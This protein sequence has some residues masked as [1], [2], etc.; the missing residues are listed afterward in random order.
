MAK[1]I[2][3]QPMTGSQR[4]AASRARRLAA[5]E[6]LLPVGFISKWDP[7][8]ETVLL[9]DQVKAVLELYEHLL[10]LTLRQIFYR[11]VG[12]HDYEKSEKA[13]NR[14]K[15]KLILARRA[16][17][18]PMT[19][20]RDDGNVIERGWGGYADADVAYEAIMDSARFSAEYL[21]L[22]RRRGQ[23]R[24]LVVWCEAAGMVPQ[25]ATIAN[26][27]AVD[28][29]SGGG[30]DSLTLKHQ[31]GQE[32]SQHP[33]TILHVGDLDKAGVDIFAALAADVTAFA[34]AY[35]G[36][37]RFERIAVTTEQAEHFRLSPGLAKPGQVGDSYQAEALDPSD[38]AD[39][40]KQAIES[41]LDMDA[42]RGVLAAEPAARR[43]VM[44]RLG[45]SPAT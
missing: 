37:L 1:R 41:R 13:Y 12:A 23:E 4:A 8:P 21:T 11:L 29:V 5:G 16:Q 45:L 30:F 26:P 39:I 10:P 9:L 27:Y 38:L 40:V 42:W 14:L 18:I 36:D 34:Q 43:E 3:A 19:A 25:L 24:H 28:T 35:G 7:R 32:W 22:D 44:A 2:G 17:I 31:V 6:R 15:A 20:I 33:T